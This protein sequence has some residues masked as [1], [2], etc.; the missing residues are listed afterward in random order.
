MKV[1]NRIF[2][3]LGIAYGAYKLAEFAV[4]K[5]RQFSWQD[6]VVIVSG[7]SRGL[8]LVL[9]RSLVE[10]GAKVMISARTAADVASAV[11]ELRALGGDVGGLVCDVRNQEQVQQVAE[12]TI[13]RWG[14]ID[15]LFNV[16]GIMQVGPLDAMTVADFREAM[17]INCW[18]VLHTTLAVLP[19]MRR[20][21]WGRIVNVASIGG[22]RA[23]P[24]M[25]PYDTSKFAVVGLS[26]GLRAELAQDG[27][28]VTTVCPS[29]MR[30][31]SPR[32]AT[33]KGQNEAEYA[34]FSI[35]GSLPLAAISA[36]N[37]ADQIMTACQ[38][39]D[40][41]VYI[42]NTFSPPLWAA[43]LAPT[44]TNELFGF[45][46]RF[47]PGMG[48]IGQQSA[49]GYES[50]SALSPSLLTTLGDSAACRNNEM[51]PRP[52]ANEV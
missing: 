24:H 44:L 40:G 3:A 25:L 6:R 28:L 49:Y 8:G 15:V 13:K 34:W 43:Q 27:I 1:S 35:G 36:E 18:G 4:R 41:E 12:A 39:G 16:A 2:Y 52:E 50:E 23:V 29:L 45:I 20:Q 31:G 14:K 19:T 9:A 30:T 17:D 7:G 51:R 47:L 33:F 10:H 37:A 26:T 22:K 5:S 21:Q 32:N 42:A 46:N 11:S 38:N 48:G